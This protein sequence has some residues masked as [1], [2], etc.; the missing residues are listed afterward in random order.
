MRSTSLPAQNMEKYGDTRLREV[1]LEYRPMYR[2][3]N[4][5]KE[6]AYGQV[7]FGLTGAGME[8]GIT[9]NGFAKDVPILMYKR[10]LKK[11]GPSWIAAPG[12]RCS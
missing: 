3:G 10:V 6:R 5:E 11:L 1:S 7:K 9:I 2:F 8:G 4:G 12:S